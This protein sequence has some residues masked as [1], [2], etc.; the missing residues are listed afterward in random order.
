LPHLTDTEEMFN[1]CE[2]LE[3]IDFENFDTNNV[4]NMKGMFK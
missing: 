1:W 3:N 2:N 4:T